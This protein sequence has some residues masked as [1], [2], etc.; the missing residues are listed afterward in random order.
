M[1]PYR[2]A[3]G[4]GKRFTEGVGVK[5]APFSG[6]FLKM[7][8]LF[9]FGLCMAFCFVSCGKNDM[10]PYTDDLENIVVALEIK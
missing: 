4:S 10:N 2:T 7:Y 1:E 3:S 9:I 6:G 8:R 5:T